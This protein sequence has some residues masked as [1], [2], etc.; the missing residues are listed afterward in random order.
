MKVSLIFLLFFFF[1]CNLN[2]TYTNEQQDQPRPE[3]KYAGIN[4][5]L[6][7]T[8]IHA[9][10]SDLLGLW[11]DGSSENATFEI[12]QDSVYYVEQFEA[13][14]YALE[15]GIIKIHYPDHMFKGRLTFE[16]DEIKIVA[17]D[18]SVVFRRFSE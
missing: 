13:Y 14:K 9:Q 18:G 17:E 4:G 3:E 11:T 5:L 15:D 6:S 16:N 1:S 7:D 12:R 10:K 2:K 8:V